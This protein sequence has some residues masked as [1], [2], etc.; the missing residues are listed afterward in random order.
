MQ[1]HFRFKSKVKP[2][3]NNTILSVIIGLLNATIKSTVHNNTSKVRLTRKLRYMANMSSFIIK[4][5]S[6]QCF[7]SLDLS[8]KQFLVQ[9]T[10]T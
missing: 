2:A 3:L 7:I 9:R 8:Q 5:G 1:P 6:L 4:S 10:D